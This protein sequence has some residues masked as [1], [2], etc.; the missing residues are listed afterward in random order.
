VSV[1]LAAGEHAMK[2]VILNRYFHPD[3]SA[4]SRMASSLGFGLAERG[5]E[6]H[7]VSSRQLLGEPQT[8]LPRRERI[9][10]VTLHR[11]WTTCFGRRNILGRAMDYLTY[12]ISVFFWIFWFTRRGDVLIVA[13]DPPLLSVLAS[14]ATTLTGAT[15]VNWLHDLY[16]EVASAL[17]IPMP[18]AGYR[19]LQW[20]RDFSLIGATMNVAIGDRMAVYVRGRGVPTDRLATVHNWSDG[21]SIRPLQARANPIRKQWGLTDRFVIGYSGNLGRGHEFET[22]LRAAEAL[23][24]KSDIVFLFIGA[25]HHLSLIEERARALG[26]SNVICRPYEPPSRLMESLGV[27]DLHLVSLRPELEGLMVPCKF[28]GIAAAGRPTVY[29]GDVDGEIPL[30]LN[31]ADCG[32]TI[33]VGDVEGLVGY[34]T[35][36]RQSPEQADR[37]GSNARDV[38]MRRFDRRHAIEQWNVI[39]NGVVGHPVG[40]SADIP[41]M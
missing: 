15:R 1:E 36:L 19:L 10:G 29:I 9:D 4:T 17:G 5:W 2:L 20:L 23:K 3:E 21:L 6:V 30:I 31:A 25:G 24:D 16:P 28:F 33:P 13:T 37:W 27:A 12:Y 26:L 41:A 39:L 11:I 14:I 38:F 40:V 34:I 35:Q 8:N 18:R 22:I 32:R 7:A